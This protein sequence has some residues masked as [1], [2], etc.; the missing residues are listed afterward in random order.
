[1]LFT[2]NGKKSSCMSRSPSSAV[3]ARVIHGYVDVAG[4]A[5]LFLECGIG[6]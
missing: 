3:E 5:S 4:M 1:M 2:L 6:R